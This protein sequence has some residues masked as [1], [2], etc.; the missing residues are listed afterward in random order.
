MITVHVASAVYV[1]AL[2]G[3]F[4]GDTCTL[5]FYNFPSHVEQQKIRFQGFD[6]PERANPKCEAERT[7][8]ARA[9]A[10]T[11]DY[12]RADVVLHASGDYDRYGRLLVQAPELKKRLIAQGLAQASPHGK[13][14]QWC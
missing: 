9:R 13:R 12:M 7:K 11:L 6:T 8:A 4:D 5:R 14:M 10:V 3:C 1:A 2:V